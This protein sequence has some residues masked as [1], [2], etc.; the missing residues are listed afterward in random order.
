MSRVSA[1]AAM[2]G[3]YAVTVFVFPWSDTRINDTWVYATD[4]RAFLHGALPYR[5]VFFEYPPLAA[6]VVTLPSFAGTSLPAYRTGL[7]V[8][9]LVLLGCVLLLVRALA[10]RTGGDQRLAMAAV[11]VAPL[12][13]G[14]VLRNHF[15]LA[16]VALTLAALVLLVDGGARAGM[17][18]LGIAVAVKGYPIVVAPV[19]VAWLVARGRRADAL[20]GGAVFAAIAA[21]TVALAVALSPAGALDALR[22]QTERPVQVESTPAAVLHLAGADARVEKS[23]RS[24]NLIHPAAGAVA[25]GIGALGAVA[26]LLL[27]MGAARTPGPRELVLAAL[28]ATAAYAAFGKVLSPQYMT[29]AIPLMALALSWRRVAI[30]AT[31]GVAAVLTFFEFPLRYRDLLSGDS[32][33]VGAV[34]LRDALL[35]TSVALCVRA[36]SARRALPA[37]A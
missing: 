19:A 37:R 16:P 36:L 4:A 18:V 11:A 7:T 12:L 25:M 10:R 35:V 17:A 30:A 24:H 23:F 22:W 28:A 15:D 8:V 29:W 31:I 1:L 13:L 14:A 3:A 21:G 34:A 2:A 33:T 26:V 20:R 32:L 27:A 9:S 5:D 6:P